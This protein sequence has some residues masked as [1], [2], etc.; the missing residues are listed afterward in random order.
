MKKLGLIINPVAGMGGRVGLKGTDGAERYHK[1]L[2]LGALPQAAERTETALR[3]IKPGDDITIYT[4]SGDMGEH[5]ARKCGFTPEIVYH[6]EARTGGEDTVKATEALKNMGVDLILFA[7]GDGTARWVGKDARNGRCHCTPDQRIPR[8]AHDPLGKRCH[9][10]AYGAGF[11][12][13]A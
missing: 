10:A 2:E 1:A 7:G 4:C 9:R 5:V 6:S 3:Q 8:G 13:H 11:P 12:R